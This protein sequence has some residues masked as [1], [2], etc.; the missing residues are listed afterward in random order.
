MQIKTTTF[1]RFRN[2]CLVLSGVSKASIRYWFAS[3][4]PTLVVGV[5]INNRIGWYAWHL[6][7]FDSPE[8]LFKT[9]AGTITIRIPQTNRLDASGWDQVRKDVFD[10]FNSLGRA[11]SNDTIMPHLLETVF[12]L[13]RI[14]GNLIRLGSSAPPAPPLTQSEGMSILIEQMELRDLIRAVRKFL[15]KISGHSEVHKQIAS[16]LTSFE[17]IA[18]KVHP[19]IEMLPPPGHDIP[20][21]LQLAFSPKHLAEARPRLILAGVDLIRILTSPTPHAPQSR[22]SASTP[23]AQHE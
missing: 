10:H 19:S 13:S 6:D 23:A 7:L 20:A 16:W 1:P 2:G 15:E 18:M 4:V 12:Q 17:D 3:P 9:N 5:D 11:L 14:A 22:D 21:D 8:A